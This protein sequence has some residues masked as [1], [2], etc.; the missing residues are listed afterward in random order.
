[1]GAESEGELQPDKYDPRD[2][3]VCMTKNIPLVL[4]FISTALP[5]HFPRIMTTIH[6]AELLVL[7]VDIKGWLSREGNQS[8][9][10][11]LWKLVVGSDTTASTSPSAGQL[12]WPP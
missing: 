7:W 3:Q 6:T 2:G 1:M 10:Q 9:M 5:I 11:E 12:L 8:M 4:V